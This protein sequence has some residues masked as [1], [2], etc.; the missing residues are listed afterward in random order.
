MLVLAAAIAGGIITTVAVSRDG[1]S[2]PD[3]AP[4]TSVVASQ[5]TATAE[6]APALGGFQYPII[7]A[8][9]PDDS[10]L[11]PG[12]PREYRQ[13]VH[14]GIDFYDA[15]GCAF[16]GLDTKVL[17]AKAGTVI[18][19]DTDYEEMTAEALDELMER[20][21]V[22]GGN[23]ATALDGFRGRQV[24]IDHGDG[25]VTRYAHLNRIADGIEAG[26]AV[27]QGT[28]IAYVGESGT[29]SSV[30]DPGSEI[31]VHFEIR[32]GESYLGYGIVGEEAV[33]AL[34]EEALAP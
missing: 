6:P 5:A 30:T 20:I 3:V 26:Q 22:Y 4:A 21:D 23:D 10:Y 28:V 34:Y 19:A 24:W 14:E 11:M 29:P 32:I 17:A 15:D 16:I 25:I 13:G 27:E 8:C 1:P 7:G 12:A 2:T 33:K 9:L 31:H 18:R